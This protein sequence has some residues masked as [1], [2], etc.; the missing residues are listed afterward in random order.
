VNAAI[1]ANIAN[2]TGSVT[3]SLNANITA[4]NAVISNHAARITTLE[5]N[6]ATQATAITNLTNIKANIA[7]VDTSI[8][9]ALSSNAI[10]ANVAAV[11]ANV[12]AA[13]SAIL[14]RANLSGALFTGN[15]TANNITAVNHVYT[16]FLNVGDQS[17]PAY[18]DNRGGSFVGN[19]FLRC[20]STKSKFR[21]HRRLFGIS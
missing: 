2:V 10:L 7:Y 20:L 11:N 9:L 14:L 17:V 4:A 13:N 15:I 5:S 21:G 8:S 18:F 3:D 12:A 1:S 6:A 16:E 19:R